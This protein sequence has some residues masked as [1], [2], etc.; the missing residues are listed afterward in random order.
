V[1]PNLEDAERGSMRALRRD[2]VEA[3]VVNFQTPDLLVNAIESFRRFYPGTSLIIVDNGSRDGSGNV[4]RELEGRWPQVTRLLFLKKNIYHGPALH[5][6]LQ[7]ASHDYVYIFDSDTITF[8]GG[9]LEEMT[10][11]LDTEPLAYAVGMVDNA[12]KRGFLAAGGVPFTRTAHMMI[13]RSMYMNLPPFVHHGQPTLANFRRAAERG[14]AVRP[15]P[16]ETYVKHLSRGTAARFGYG[17]GIRG[18]MDYVLNKLG[19]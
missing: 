1:K 3:L 7:I 10:G 12:N 17:L 11:V 5:R 8:R 18:K 15:F 16:I 9:F 13:R 6:G 2:T 19:L 4:L 14:Y